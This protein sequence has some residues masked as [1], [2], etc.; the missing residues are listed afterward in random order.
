MNNKTR[1]SQVAAICLVMTA[2][3]RTDVDSLVT[4]RRKNSVPFEIIDRQFLAVQVLVNGHKQKFIFD[5]GIGLTL[6]SESLCE[7]IAC[8]PSGSYVGRRMSGQKL[9]VPTTEAAIS[10]SKYTKE[11]EPVGVHNFVDD[12]PKEW[13]V[14]GFLSLHFFKDQIVTINYDDHT[15]DVGH[16]TSIQS[17]SILASSPIRIH[18]DGPSLDISIS[19]QVGGQVLKN[20]EIDTGSGALI[21]HE[22]FMEKLGVDPNSDQVERR[23]GKDETANTYVKYFT[24]LEQGMFPTGYPVARKKIGRVLFQEIIYDGLVGTNFLSQFNMAYDLVNA[25]LILARRN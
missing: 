2:C 21:L 1:L 10:L 3:V 22:R 7:T 15:I 13:G 9:K 8:Q 23:T 4:S 25:K 11:R 6:I 20:L 12:L 18:H 5:T 17:R 24:N 19:M 14:S 16:K